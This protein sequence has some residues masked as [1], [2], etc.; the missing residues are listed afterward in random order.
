MLKSSPR[1]RPKTFLNSFVMNTY[2]SKA[3][4]LKNDLG[5]VLRPN[6]KIQNPSFKLIV[7]LTAQRAQS[8]ELMV[9]DLCQ[10]ALIKIVV[11]RLSV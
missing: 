1:R 11:Y 10:L 6:F 2:S 7:F 4:Q 3:K 5:R 8:V 9:M